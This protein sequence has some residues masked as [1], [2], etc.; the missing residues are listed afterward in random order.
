M[1]KLLL[2]GMQ[3]PENKENFDVS[4]EVR[5]SGVPISL[6]LPTRGVHRIGLDVYNPTMDLSPYN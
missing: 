1:N 6:A 5:S 2:V 4:S 3:L